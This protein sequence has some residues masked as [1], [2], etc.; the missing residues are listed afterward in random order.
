M[1][2]KLIC[3]FL[4]LVMMFACASVLASCGEDTGDTACSHYDDNKDGKCDDCGEVIDK[5][6]EH[7]DANGDKI[8]TVNYG[9]STIDTMSFKYGRL[10][11]CAK[12]PFALVTSTLL[13]AASVT[14]TLALSTDFALLSILVLDCS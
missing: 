9:L 5:G 11:M 3:L 8:Y 7:T 4:A 14:V 12:V 1:K 2:K 13:V 6:C 10:E